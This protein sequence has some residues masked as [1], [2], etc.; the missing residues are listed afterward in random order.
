[1]GKIIFFM[2]V[3]LDGYFEGVNHDLS[4]H[5]VDEE[6]NNN[7]AIPMLENTSTLLFGRRTYE[8][9][10]EY[11]P[12]ENARNDDPNVANFMNTLPKIVFSKTLDKVDEDK[13]WKNIKL[14]HEVNSDEIKKLK[15][16]SQKDIAILG[17]NSLCV[18]LMEKNLVDEF[19]IMVNPVAIGKGTPLFYGIKKK[20]K[21]KYI[22]SQEFKNGNVLLCY[23]I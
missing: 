18:S 10:H 13:Y 22:K 21:L 4:W 7:H 2:M 17:S 16:S 12:T 20:V 6:F 1:M 15:E 9:M 19:R 8:L 23:S 5:N 3:S 11:W 14:M